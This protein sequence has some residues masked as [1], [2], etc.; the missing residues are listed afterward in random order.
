M[1]FFS[2]PPFTVIIAADQSNARSILI[3][4]TNIDK[5]K[6]LSS[7]SM[8]GVSG[9]NSDL[10]NFTEYV[11]PS[12]R[13]CHTTHLSFDRWPIHSFLYRYVSKNI[14]LYELSN[15]GTKLSTRAQANYARGELATALR[16][17]PY[18]VNIMMGGYDPKIGSSLF[19]LDYMGTLHK[20][21]HGAQGY[22]A[23]FCSSIFDKEYTSPDT[24]TEEQALEII[25]HCI[26]EVQ[27]RFM[28]SQ[29]NFMIKKVDKDGVKVVSFG[30]DP[31]DT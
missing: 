22:A 25:Q 20:V 10:V 16:K 2:A 27:T 28:V 11:F 3:Y 23:Y 29:P 7:H 31:A 18:Q 26:N 24:C 14:N 5:I 19:F 6:E 12:K 1:L 13:A 21:P 9:A 30:G 17:G 15:D 8:M 4:Q